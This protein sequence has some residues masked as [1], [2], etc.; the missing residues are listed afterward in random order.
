MYH[1]VNR[2]HR[3]AVGIEDLITTQNIWT[4]DKKQTSGIRKKDKRSYL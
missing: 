2:D 1:Q 3:T 4:I